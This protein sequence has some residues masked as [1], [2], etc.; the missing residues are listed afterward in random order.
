[1]ALIKETESQ[2]GLTA[3]YWAISNI[4][5]NKETMNLKCKLSLYLV[6]GA[7]KALD[8]RSLNFSVTQEDIANG[9]YAAC[10]AEAKKQEWLDG[11]QDG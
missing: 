10:Y 5:F 4:E 11:A 2:Y 7:P 9:F 8:I 1:M 6:K 3:D